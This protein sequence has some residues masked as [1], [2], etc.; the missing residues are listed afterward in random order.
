MRVCEPWAPVPLILGK[1]VHMQPAPLYA[2]T[3]CECTGRGKD[4][5]EYETRV[6]SGEH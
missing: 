3:L 6:V 1:F 5:V 2:V 4:G